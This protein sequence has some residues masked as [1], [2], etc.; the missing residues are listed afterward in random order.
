MA[1]A[2]AKQRKI[3]TIYRGKTDIKEL[4]IKILTS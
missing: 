1:K 3:V 4:I 2:K